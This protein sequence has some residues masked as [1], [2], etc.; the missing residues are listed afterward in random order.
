MVAKNKINVYF[1]T[2]IPGIKIQIIIIAKSTGLFYLQTI[3]AD[4]VKILPY[5]GLT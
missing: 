5:F 2:H 4:N 3:A 1:Y